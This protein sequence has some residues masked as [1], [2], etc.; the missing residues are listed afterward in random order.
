[1]SAS[2]TASRRG[3]AGSGPASS[4]V[5]VGRRA[6]VGRGEHAA[7]QPEAD[8]VGQHPLVGLVRRPR[9]R[10]GPGRRPGPGTPKTART[11]YGEASSRSTA[12]TPSTI[13]GPA[14]RGVPSGRSPAFRSRKSATRGSAGSVMTTGAGT[15]RFCPPPMRSLIR[16]P[17]HV[18]G[19]PGPN[20]RSVIGT[21]TPLTPRR[22]HLALSSS[23][24][25]F[26]EDAMDTAVT[27]TD[28]VVDRGRRRVLT[29]ST[30]RRRPRPGHRA[31]RP[32]RQRQ[33]H[34]DARRRRR[35]A[36]ALRRGHRARRSPPARPR[37]AHRVGYVTQAPSV[38]ADL[39]VREN[40]RYFAALYG[41]RRAPRPTPRSP[42]SASADAAGQLVGDLS[43]GQRGRASLACALVG[44]PRAAGARRADGRAWTRC[45]GSSCGSASTPSPRRDD[46]AGLQ[47]RDGRGRPLRPAAA[48]PRRRADRRRHPRAAARR[49]RHRRPRGGVPAASIRAREEVAA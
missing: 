32:E 48:A 40:V 22:T 37:C 29:G 42:T 20:D 1:M 41:R 21:R 7:G 30:L 10:A 45:C 23:V 39:T 46:A 12:G 47:P 27:V 13:T 11:R 49:R 19:E 26:S 34:A 5:Q 14:P 17:G 35:P 24:V 25:E 15:P 33:D 3:A 36:G 28:L 44:A 16:G 2:S 31:A 9:R 6:P 4:A 8:H 18:D 38:Y 43:G